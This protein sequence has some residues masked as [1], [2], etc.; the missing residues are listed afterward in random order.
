M[1]CNGKKNHHFVKEEKS[2]LL[3]VGKK[4]R[5][6]LCVCVCVHEKERVSVCVQESLYVCVIECVCVGE[7][8]C[9]CVS[10]SYPPALF[11]CS[12]LAK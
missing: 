7:F 12:L 11:L 9:V 2:K 1:N 5:K 6:S 8:F 10:L 3:F 4:E